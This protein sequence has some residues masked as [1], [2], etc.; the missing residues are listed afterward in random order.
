MPETAL[1]GARVYRSES[2]ERIVRGW[3]RDRLDEYPDLSSVAE[4]STSLGPTRAFRM[5]GGSGAPVVVL[6]GTN[7]NSA[8]S[9]SPASDMTEDRDVVLVD[10]PG[11]PGL[12]C[13]LRPKGSRAQAYGAWLD[14][15][16]PELVDRPAIVLGH[17]LGGAVAL[18]SQPCDLVKGLVLVNPAGLT[19]VATS[20]EL[21]RVTLPWM[22]NPREDKS[23]RLLN[24]MSGPAFRHPVHPFAAWMTMVGRHCRTSLAPGPLVLET[25][26]RWQGGNVLAATGSDDVFFPPSRLKAP[27]RR[28]LG[29]ELRVLEGAGHLSLY[30]SAEKV[31]ALV[32]EADG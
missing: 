20:P 28:F 21:M 8:L 17:S 18:A 4:I 12:S 1:H 22:I 3:C 15:V 14:E 23:T 24:F 31:R 6:S 5:S 26:L 2:A 25:L 11:Q 32:T 9:A 16:L 30:E 29:S 7:F 27:V 13:G 10:L 19:G